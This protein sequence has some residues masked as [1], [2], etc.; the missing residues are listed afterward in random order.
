M[1]CTLKWWSVREAERR[2]FD[3]NRLYFYTVEAEKQAAQ[4]RISIDDRKTCTKS[5]N[6]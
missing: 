5:I 1:K 4:D 3:E 2:S 6:R